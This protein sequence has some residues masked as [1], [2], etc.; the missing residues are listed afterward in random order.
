MKVQKKMKS[1]L[2]KGFGRLTAIIALSSQAVLGDGQASSQGEENKFYGFNVG[3]GY[4]FEIATT[5]DSYP[6]ELSI[7]KHDLFGK[8]AKAIGKNSNYEN[9]NNQKDLLAK[10]TQDGEDLVAIENNSLTMEVPFKNI[11][12]DNNK[13]AMSHYGFLS[14]GYVS[15]FGNV[16]VEPVLKFKLKGSTNER[17]AGQSEIMVY[18]GYLGDSGPLCNKTYTEVNGD[19]YIDVGGSVGD[20]VVTMAEVQFNKATGNIL[21]D[22]NTSSMKADRWYA[23]GDVTSGGYGY[24]NIGY[25]AGNSTDNDL[26]KLKDALGFKNTTGTYL[27]NTLYAERKI[28]AELKNTFEMDAHVNVGYR[29]HPS[30]MAYGILGMSLDCYKLDLKKE[31]VTFGLDNGESNKGS[32]KY[33]GEFDKNKLVLQSPSGTNGEPGNGAY[34]IGYLIKAEDRSGFKELKDD[35]VTSDSWS[36]EKLNSLKAD[37]GYATESTSVTENNKK[38]TFIQLNADFGVG[39]GVV[40]YK[41]VTLRA[42]FVYS[43]PLN[44]EKKMYDDNVTLTMKPHKFKFNFGAVVPLSMIKG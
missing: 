12:E 25:G 35:K 26:E 11:G 9:L 44:K 15:Q 37:A 18:T 29:L 41:G 38:N 22:N 2:L 20:L 8:Q 27:N 34:K 31:T 24:F 39:I 36:E 17:K 5:T 32:F 33:S 7:E 13:N 40:V 1:K 43:L 14:L 42:E 28:T 21:K 23:I 6:G 4:G 19:T 30:V 16:I 10:A 3:L